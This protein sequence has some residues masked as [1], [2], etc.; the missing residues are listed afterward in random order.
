M[1]SHTKALYGIIA[2]LVV[3]IG[4][5]S[6]SSNVAIAPDTELTGSEES[7]AD[8]PETTDKDIDEGETNDPPPQ[9][10]NTQKTNTTQTAPKTTAPAS[11]HKVF[12][13]T[14]EN[15]AY[16]ISRMD[17][18]VGDTVTINLTS[19]EDW[20]DLWIDDYR[21]EIDSVRPG[22]PGTETF[23]ADKVGVFD[24]YSRVG[25]NRQQGME[26]LF[27]VTY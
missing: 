10:T 5:L 1:T 22:R 17:A 19:L 9:N 7:A 2:I 3:I 4:Y 27:V 26:G 23:V 8:A 18:K 21:V 11:T 12:N 16:N 25:N 6:Y 13:V 14:A 15:F 24:F 20:Q